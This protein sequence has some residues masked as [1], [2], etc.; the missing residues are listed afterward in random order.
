[1]HCPD[2]HGTMIN[3]FVPAKEGL[4]FMRHVPLSHSPSFAQGL[5]STSAHMRRA[6]L[7]AYKC[8]RCQLLVLRY[9]RQIDDPETFQRDEDAGAPL[10]D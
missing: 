2:C 9:G 8:P 10:T 7:E 5:P 1:M 3:G 6:Y 4:M